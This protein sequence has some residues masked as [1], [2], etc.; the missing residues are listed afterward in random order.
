MFS[1]A[2]HKGKYHVEFDASLREA[3]ETQIQDMDFLVID[4]YIYD[5]YSV[6]RNTV[7]PKRIYVLE[8]LEETKTLQ[9]CQELLSILIS[10]GFKRNHKL[11]AVGGGITQ[12]VTSFTAS[13]LYRGIGW[14]FFPTTLLAQADSCIG[15]KTSINFSNAKNL[16][17]SFH[18]PEKIICCPEFL[19]TLPRDD[20]RSGIGEMLHYYIYA[21]SHLLEDI[22]REYSKLLENPCDLMG[23]YI[24]ESLTIKREM[25]Q[26]DEFDKGERRVF[27]YGHTF[28]HAIEALSNYRISHGL[29]VTIGM[30]IANYIALRNNIIDKKTYLYF[31]KHLKNNL[32]EYHIGEDRIEDYYDLLTKDKKNTDGDI[33][34]ILPYGI[35][36]LR[37]TKIGNGTNISIDKLK[38]DLKHYMEGKCL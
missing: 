15:S 29:A 28:G 5:E 38:K 20:I 17:G 9:T 14:K 35:K 4:K 21:D 1:V 3:V 12:D 31:H 7:D 36:D 33:V 11:V 18:P 26:R 25:A 2:S 19:K 27:N 37:V 6:F 8:A 23:R 22:T 16:L 32:T 30:D 34:C 13:V 10:S 24:K